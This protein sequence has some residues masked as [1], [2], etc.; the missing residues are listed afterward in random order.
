MAVIVIRS[1]TPACPSL[2][3]A[4]ANG[5]ASVACFPRVNTGVPWCDCAIGLVPY[6]YYHY[7][8]H[9]HPGN[10]C[11]NQ[12][13]YTGIGRFPKP[14]SVVEITRCPNPTITQP[15]LT[16]G[17][18]K[19][20]IQLQFSFPRFGSSHYL[21]QTFLQYPKSKTFFIM[22]A[23]ILKCRADVRITYSGFLSPTVALLVALS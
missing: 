20:I 17:R 22:K 3:D 6:C 2:G 15:K 10:A 7:H 8:Q 9:H 5:A 4:R 19:R 11:A 21:A 12:P 13:R 23:L 16:Q 18:A 1:L 14:G